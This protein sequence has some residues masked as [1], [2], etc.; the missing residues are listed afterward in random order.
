MK[1]KFSN[2]NE[3]DKDITDEEFERL[4]APF[5]NNADMYMI[6]Y[7]IP[8]V[9]SF[10]LANYYY[11]GCLDKSESSLLL[12][13]SSMI[14]LFNISPTLEETREDIERLLK[15]KY[16]LKIISEDPLRF[17]KWNE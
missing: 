10:Q 16:N 13:Y 8:E 3:D 17:D 6:K 15:I 4:Y 12:H 9:I 11:R 5:F 1:K 2:V 7:V 14:D